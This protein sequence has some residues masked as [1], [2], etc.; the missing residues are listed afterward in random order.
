MT[1]AVK[2]QAVAHLRTALGMRERRAYAIVEAD[3]TSMRHRSGRG[4]EGDRRSR[5]HK[6]TQQRRRFGYR[7]LHIQLRR[8]GITINPKKPQRL[9]REDGLTVRRRRGPKRAV[10]ARASPPVL[11]LLNQRWSRDF[12]HDQMATAPRFRI[13]NIV[14]DV[15]REC[16]RAVLDTSIS[17]KRVVRELSD[18][19]AELGASTM[20]VSYNETRLTSNAVLA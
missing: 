19:L 12:A 20:I 16:L 4:D 7:R 17:G 2:Q 14:E 3:R 5:L 13:V 9:Y 8:D 1:P 15:T 18:L 10:R 6:L 11:A